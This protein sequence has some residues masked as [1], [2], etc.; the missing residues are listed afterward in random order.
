MTP[1][2][3]GMTLEIFDME[4][5]KLTAQ[6]A[7]RFRLT[8]TRPDGTVRVLADWFDN[9]ITDGG[10]NRLGTGA[11]AE[12]CRVGSGNTT[13]ANGDTA[14][15][16]Q[17]A[18]ADIYSFTD[19]YDSV[20]NLY[21]YRRNVYRFSTGSAAG[22][23]SEVGVGWAGGALFSRALIKDGGG[24]PTTITVLA[25]EILDVVYELRIYR[26]SAD[27]DTGITISGVSYTCTVRAANMGSWRPNTLMQYGAGGDGNQLVQGWGTDAALGAVTGQPSGTMNVGGVYAVTQGSYSSGSYQRAFRVVVGIASGTS[28]IKALIFYTPC[29]I[30]QMLVAPNIPKDATNRLTLDFNISWARR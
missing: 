6:V 4:Q 1:K 5:N 30:Y 18:E 7:G 17:V 10:L 23:L 3:L 12:K 27:V 2:W 28:A 8:A 16:T 21:G 19:G 24:A 20:G 11:V 22:N 15:V 26:P 9:L 14:L 29:G 13:P 25:D